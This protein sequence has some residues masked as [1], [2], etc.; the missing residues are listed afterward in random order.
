MPA[1]GADEIF[2]IGGFMFSRTSVAV[3]ID[4]VPYTGIFEV[5]GEE[6]R[7]GELQHGQRTD[8]TPLGITSGLYTPG[9]LTFKTYGMDTGE[10]ILLAAVGAGS[11]LAS[12][13]PSSPLILQ[14]F[15]NPAAA[16]AHDPVVEGEDREA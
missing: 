14:V 6:A 12:A 2:R 13:T 16:G 8:G 4:G 10:Q 9:P 15:E 5:N 1:I 3:T 11:G 7:E